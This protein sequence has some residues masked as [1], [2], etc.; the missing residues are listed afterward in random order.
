MKNEI[1]VLRWGTQ[2][3]KCSIQIWRM[4]IVSQPESKEIFNL[5]FLFFQGSQEDCDATEMLIGNAQN[6]MQSVK[7]SV[8]A[9]EIASNKIRL[10]DNGLRLNWNRRIWLR[11]QYLFF[12]ILFFFAWSIVNDFEVFSFEC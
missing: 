10:V 12:K 9:A 5:D 8:K 1:L 2:L 11:E 7:E 4:N 6:L 3:F